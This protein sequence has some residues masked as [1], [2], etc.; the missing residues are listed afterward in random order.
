[1]INPIE[2]RGIKMKKTYL[3]TFAWGMAVGAVVLLIVIFSA[4][5]VVTSSSAKSMASEISFN[6]VMD[7]LAPIAVAQFMLDPNK[8]T[9][10][11]A[12][13]KLDS[14]GENSR[15]DYVQKQGWAT[16]PGEKE[17]DGQVADEVARRLMELKI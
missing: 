14:W 7:R 15:S 2:L 17:P 16:M 4:G 6:A 10:L 1:M 9:R 12:M 3:K 13:K 5:W 11:T 8:E